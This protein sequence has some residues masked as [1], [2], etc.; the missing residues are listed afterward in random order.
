[1]YRLKRDRALSAALDAEFERDG[2]NAIILAGIGAALK[3]LHNTENKISIFGITL[4]LNDNF[5]LNG[6]VCA[7]AL[8]Y[9]LSC[10]LVVIKL[11]GSGWPNNYEA[12]LKR[13]IARRRNKSG[14]RYKPKAAKR[15]ARL[16][17]TFINLCLLLFACILIPVY[18]YGV[19]TTFGDLLIL[20][21][22][23]FKLPVVMLFS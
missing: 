13:Y 2:R 5:L 6:A 15:E 23:V 16:I 7:T 18:V 9:G 22:Q 12:F 8:Y 1:M 20:L 19:A 17:C 14:S 4:N 11:Y 21:E 3:F 10:F